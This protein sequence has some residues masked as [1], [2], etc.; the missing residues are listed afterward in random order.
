LINGEKRT[1]RAG[2]TISVPPLTKHKPFNETSEPVLVENED[3]KT[4]PVEFG[5]HLSQLYGFMDQYPGGPNMLRMLMQLS[6]YGTE[7]DSYIADGPSLGFQKSMRVLMAPT[8]RLL[9]Y[10]NYYEEYRPRHN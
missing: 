8:A 9:G 3:E 4:L 6:V 7:A 5:Y 1:L 2:E 10:R